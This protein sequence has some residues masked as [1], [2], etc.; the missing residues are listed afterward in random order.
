MTSTRPHADAAVV[1]RHD[2]S[3]HV[4]TAHVRALQEILRSQE[5]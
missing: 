2:E 4:C 3:S 1:L 5:A